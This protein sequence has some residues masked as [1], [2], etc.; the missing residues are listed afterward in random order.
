MPPSQ[1]GPADVSTFGA[2]LSVWRQHRGMTKKGLAEAMGFDPSY[3]SHVEAGRHAA[4]EEFARAAESRLSAGGALWQA[5]QI[6]GTARPAGTP[7]GNTDGLIV[8]EDH[9]RLTFDGTTYQPTQQRHLYNA[10]PDPVTRWLM[11]ISVDRYPGQ[12]ERSNALYRARP[13]AWDELALTA[14]CDGEPMTWRP[15]HDRDSFKEA[16]L[17][18]ENDRGRFPL[19]PGQ[20]A[21]VRYSY[22]VDV[23]RWGHW[24]QRAVR[25]PTRHLA[26]ELAFPTELDPAVWGTETSTTAEAVPLHA[27]ITRST[28]D[29]GTI[30]VFQWS[31]KDPPIGA[32]Y[33]LEWRFRAHDDN[34]TDLRPALR[35]ASDRMKAAGIIQ[36][37]DP[38]LGRTARPFDLPS[39]AEEAN[40]V[41]DQ[42]FAAMQRVREHHVFGKGMGLAA[43]QIGIECAAAIVQ[44]PDPEADP[45]VLLN[46]RVTNTSPDTD[47]QYEGCLS[48]FDVR[49]LVPRPLHLEI[50]HTRIDGSTA[51]TVL[52]ASMARLAS[53]EID[54]LYG[55]LYTDRMRE[56]LA[57]IPVERYSGTG[58]AWEY[59]KA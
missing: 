15:K 32:R 9:A 29:D 18:L 23:G 45:L 46:P 11:R 53:H 27:P 49:G 40:D 44:P 26:V 14:T 43:P 36:R 28:S 51:I 37:G 4:S 20:R 54:H 39:E 13:L 58:Q 5:W 24:F 31:T 7:A 34:A 10:G 55:H 6:S 2:A 21:T 38:I 12:P 57:P 52:D 59:H 19:Y 42:L 16:W 50:A 41:I 47:E 56:G 22:Q 1:S 33:R 8:E 48:F 3:V 25:L 35:T 30:T 17:C